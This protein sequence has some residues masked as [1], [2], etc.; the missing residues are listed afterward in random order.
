MWKMVAA[1]P[2]MRKMEV[3]LLS[4]I[5]KH[6]LNKLRVKQLHHVDRERLVGEH[7]HIDMYVLLLLM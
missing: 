7:Q 6:Q 4:I 2:I 3:K 5:L 1:H